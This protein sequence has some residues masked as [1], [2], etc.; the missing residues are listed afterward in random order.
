MG[1]SLS[2]VVL[3]F[4]ADLYGS[5]YKTDAAV[6]RGSKHRAAKMKIKRGVLVMSD[7]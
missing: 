1:K 2:K 3:V 6:V 5:T 4:E 7:K